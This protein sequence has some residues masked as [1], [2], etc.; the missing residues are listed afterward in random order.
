MQIPENS[1]ACKSAG[2]GADL[3][4]ADLVVELED[5][6]DA[7]FDVL[8][9]EGRQVA[10]LSVQQSHQRDLKTSKRGS[11]ATASITLGRLMG[12]KAKY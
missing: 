6:H 1:Q 11:R 5:V 7:V 4:W 8:E 3:L 2:S 10:I 9:S 12:V